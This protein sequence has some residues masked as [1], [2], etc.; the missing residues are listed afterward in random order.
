MIRLACHGEYETTLLN[1]E[2]S[3]F[4]YRLQDKLL[5]YSDNSLIE[6]GMIQLFTDDKH[7]M[8]LDGDEFESMKEDLAKVYAETFRLFD[9][10]YNIDV[11]K[12]KNTQFIKT[13]FLYVPKIISRKKCIIKKGYVYCSIYE[14][15]T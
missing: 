1:F 7:I 2:T 8:Q 9:K 14:Y 4:N 5:N 15:K 6:Y 3:L 11:N 10:K 12:L 13:K